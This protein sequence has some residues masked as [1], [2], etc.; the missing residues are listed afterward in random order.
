MLLTTKG[1]MMVDEVSY[2]KMP[3]MNYRA[4]MKELNKQDF[5]II[6]QPGMGEEN[7]VKV[8][9]GAD[10][11]PLTIHAN[12]INSDG[13]Q[14]RNL[15]K[16]LERMGFVAP[17]VRKKL[18]IRAKRKIA[19]EGFE[20]QCPYCSR[21]G[22][23]LPLHKM[24]HVKSAHLAEWL[25]DHPEEA[26]SPTPEPEVS[27]TRPRSGRVRKRQVQPESKAHQIKLLTRQLSNAFRTIETA[28]PEIVRIAEELEE[29]NKT[30]NA[31]IQR[32]ER[33]FGRLVDE[34]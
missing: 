6:A 32:I 12:T 16:G 4:L 17:S 8:H 25:H 7:G 29:E 13:P 1:G 34:L 28:L 5:V 23:K 3:Y 21:N 33:G 20:P 24:R 30:S 15:V 26:P 19:P 14:F 27:V 22:F 31:K 10:V 2:E 9:K 18:E 11:T